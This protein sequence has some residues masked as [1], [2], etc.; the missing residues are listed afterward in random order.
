MR[1][2]YLLMLLLLPLS[3]HAAPV[4]D[5]DESVLD[6]I[7]REGVLKVCT[8]GDYRP[9]SFFDPR[10]HEYQGIDIELAHHLAA[11]LGA[12]A[13][14]IPST[15]A[16][17]VSDLRAGKCEIA[18]GGVSVSLNRQKQAYYSIPYLRDGKTAIAR[19]EHVDK[20]Q[21]LQQIDRPKITVIVNPGGTNE[22]FV[23][24]TIK[25]ARIIVYPDNNTIFEQLLAG[26]ADVMLTD[27]IETRLQQKLHPGLCA[28][29]PEAPFTFSEKA[30]LLPRGD[31]IFKQYVDQWLRQQENNGGL[32]ETIDMGMR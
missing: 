18:M 14:F 15:W 16:S 10:T 30:Y 7:Q 32:R 3:A 20:L 26:R 31:D 19:C 1:M 5:E 22:S 27:A 4:V 12:K 13:Q 17:L 23:R 11:S 24:S 6:A 29:H 28:V 8:T 25:N 9:F 2:F 21:T